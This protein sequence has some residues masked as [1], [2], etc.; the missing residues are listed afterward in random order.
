MALE[1]EVKDIEYCPVCRT[2]PLDDI[3]S[4]IKTAELEF[5]LD[6]ATMIELMSPDIDKRFSTQCAL[7]SLARSLHQVWLGKEE[8]PAPPNFNSKIPPYP[9]RSREYSYGY[10][11]TV[12]GEPNSAVGKTTLYLE[13]KTTSNN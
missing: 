12:F 3:V 1:S 7:Y 11:L 2:L 6:D 10:S 9:C 8:L 5:H 4:G 13:T